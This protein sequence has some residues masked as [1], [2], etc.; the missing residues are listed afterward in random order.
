MANTEELKRL[1]DERDRVSRTVE[2]KTIPRLSLGAWFYWL[3]L[4]VITPLIVPV[5]V[6]IKELTKP[7]KRQRY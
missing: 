2:N 1:A 7:F 6:L 5:M 3:A 4:A